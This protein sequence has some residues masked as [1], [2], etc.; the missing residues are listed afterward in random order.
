MIQNQ[1]VLK[2][3]DALS[4]RL[5]ESEMGEYTEEEALLADVGEIVREFI[6]TEL[7]ELGA[8]WVRGQDKGQIVSVWACGAD[9]WPDIA[10]DVRGLPSVAIT[11]R[12][13]GRDDSLA[14]VLAHA[15]GSA[16]VHSVQY[17]CAIPFVLDQTESDPRQH[18]FDSEIQER[19]W[20]GHRVSLVISRSGRL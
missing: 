14:D 7:G 9:F 1:D 5:L 8:V 11:V 6:N 17:S 12:L 4:S 2:I 3:V 10:V 18:W 20:D 19:L 16:I 13:A 15:V